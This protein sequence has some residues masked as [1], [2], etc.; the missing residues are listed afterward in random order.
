M[1]RIAVFSVKVLKDERVVVIAEQRPDCAEEEVCSLVYWQL[2][3]SH[4][5]VLIE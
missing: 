4:G 5:H 1:Y 2:V 3:M